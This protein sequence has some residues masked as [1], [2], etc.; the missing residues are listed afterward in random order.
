MPEGFELPEVKIAGSVEPPRRVDGVDACRGAIGERHSNVQQGSPLA[1][2]ARGQ[3]VANLVDAGYEV[4]FH[5]NYVLV[6]SEQVHVTVDTDHL[7]ASTI[8]LREKF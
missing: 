2:V 3:V 6:V 7:D 1:A 4:S 5:E 8:C